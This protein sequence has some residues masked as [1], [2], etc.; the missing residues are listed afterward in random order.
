M[1]ASGA[2]GSLPAALRAV[3]LRPC[4]SSRRRSGVD[5]LC[6]QRNHRA[7]WSRLFVTQPPRPLHAALATRPLPCWTAS[8]RR[9]HVIGRTLLFATSPSCPLGA[10]RSADRADFPSGY[11]YGASGCHMPT[12]QYRKRPFT[13]SSPGSWIRGARVVAVRG[14]APRADRTGGGSPPTSRGAERPCLVRGAWVVQ[15]RFR[16]SRAPLRGVGARACGFAVEAVRVAADRSR[17]AWA[18]RSRSGYGSRSGPCTGEA[19][20]EARSASSPRRI[21]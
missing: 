18:R 14:S 13:P 11:R 10:A 21:G 5:A 8:R 2:V 20:C 7:S 3:G 16:G 19:R 1:F 9:H 15:V 6:S 17:A 12:S 4:W